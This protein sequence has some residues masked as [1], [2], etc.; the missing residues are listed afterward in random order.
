M[1]SKRAWEFHPISST[2]LVPNLTRHLMT[3]VIEF[4]ISPACSFLEITFPLRLRFARA[5][6][7]ILQLPASNLKSTQDSPLSLCSLCCNKFGLS[8]RHVRNFY[9]RDAQ[10]DVTSRW[11]ASPGSSCNFSTFVMLCSDNRWCEN[12]LWSR[13]VKRCRITTNSYLIRRIVHVIVRQ[14]V[15]DLISRSLVG[16]FWKLPRVW[17]AWSISCMAV[18][19]FSLYRL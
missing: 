15:N 16:P 11:M 7:Q 8:Y 12:F 17:S 2:H 14:L 19:G 1:I 18:M 9:D 5:R 4:R 10:N 3:R 6:V 13:C